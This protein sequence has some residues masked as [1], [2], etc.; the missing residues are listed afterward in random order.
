VTRAESR[1]AA[2]AE[3]RE[4]LITAALAEF[5][6]RGLDTPSLDAICAR[7]GFTRGAF[8]VHFRDRDDLVVAAMERVLGA[9]LDA[10]IGRGE[11]AG[12]APAPPDADG[13]APAAPDLPGDAAAAPDLEGAVTRFAEAL[14]ALSGQAGAGTP[15]P[16]TAELASVPLH[17]LLEACV[18]SPAVGARFTALLRE[19]ILRLAATARAGQAATRLRADV[20]P[21]ALATVLVAL[22]VGVLTVMEAGLPVDV[23]TARRAVMTV[24]A[25]EQ[26]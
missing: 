10:V 16:R 22:A 2:K 1:S 18:R 14:R 23:E 3:T 13:G 8:Y 20:D 6:A 25:P 21:D 19:A 24:L 4:A 15:G 17:R 26:A 7:A 5:R 11:A 12:A 9:F